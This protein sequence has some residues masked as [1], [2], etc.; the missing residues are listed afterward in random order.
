M[1]YEDRFIFTYTAT[2]YDNA[3]NC[4]KDE[5]GILYGTDYKD[6][7]NQL[8]E[9]Y[10]DEL[11]NIK[12]KSHDAYAPLRFTPKHLIYITELIDEMSY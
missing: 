8:A 10:G 4:E 3:E 7:F 12:I 9:L 11:V 5:C 2:Y 6:I 1:K